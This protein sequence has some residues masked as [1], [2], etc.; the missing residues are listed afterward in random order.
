MSEL[1]EK[2]H[3]RM[4]EV[5]LQV[6]YLRPEKVYDAVADDR[7]DVGL[8]SYPEPTREIAVIQWREEEMVLAAAPS[9]PLAGRNRIEPPDLEDTEFISFDDDL[10]IA[11]EIARYLRAHD[12]TVRS[13][14]HFDNLQTIKEAVMHGSAV[15]IVPRRILRTEVAS[16]RI[17]AVALAKPL[18]RPLGIIHRKR[19]RFA[20]SVQAV[21][22]MLQESSEP[23][24]VV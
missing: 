8:V 11:R 16:G 2:L 1:E 23:A 4:P 24:A 12:V 15:S 9:H 22:E 14:M 3:H 17:A 6:N 21:L 7:A 13:T 19:K 5:R 18:Y 20:P 10:P